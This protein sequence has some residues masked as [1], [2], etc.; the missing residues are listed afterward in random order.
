MSTST[1]TT[2]SKPAGDTV[3]ATRKSASNPVAWV[4]WV[5]VGSGL[6]YGLGQTAIKASALFTG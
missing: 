2:A 1:S 5:L 6:L 3:E 4:L